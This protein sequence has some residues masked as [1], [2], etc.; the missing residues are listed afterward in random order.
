MQTLHASIELL[1]QSISLKTLLCF[2]YLYTQLPSDSKI[3]NDYPDM[4]IMHNIM[5]TN[6]HAC[7]DLDI[8]A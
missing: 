1:E 8:T 6:T 4:I 3:I 2:D 7:P 5:I